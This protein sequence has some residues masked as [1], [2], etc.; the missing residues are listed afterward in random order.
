MHGGNG[1]QG[2]DDP[3]PDFVSLEELNLLSAP[4]AE[5]F[6]TA[7]CHCRRWAKDM[8]AARPYAN[9]R[10]LRNNAEAAWQD[11]TEAEILEA[12][13]GHARIGDLSALQEKYSAASR[14]QGEQMADASPEILEQLLEENNRYFEQNGFIFIVCAS[15]KSAKEMLT[16]LRTRSFNAR[17]QE[18]MNGAAEQSKIT[19]LRLAERV[20]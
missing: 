14:E 9:Q 3:T 18:L 17:H 4:V 19:A 11:A 7:I 16:L 5:D 1:P 6:F 13:A 2:G 20:R 8:V 10:E 12:F 15:G